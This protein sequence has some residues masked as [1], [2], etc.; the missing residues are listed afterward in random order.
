MASIPI[1]LATRRFAQLPQ[2]SA[3]TWQG[4]LVKLPAWVGDPGDANA[5]PHRVVGALWVSLRTGLVHV[6]LPREGEQPSAELALRALFEFGQKHAKELAGRPARLEVDDAAL[7]DELAVALAPT[8]T[9]VDVVEDLPHV[10]TVLRSFEEAATGGERQPG[11]L[12]AR[13]VT[14]AHVDGFAGAAAAFYRRA[15]WNDLDN[16]DLL[17][18]AAPAA[19]RGWGPYLSVMGAAGEE[20]GV[21]F[22]ETERAF[23]RLLEGRAP[24]RTRSVSFGPIHELPFAD[25]DAWDEQRLPVAGPDAYPIAAEMSRGESIRRPDAG[26]LVYVEAVLRALAATTAAELDA[27]VWQ[28]DVETATGSIAV[29]VS[30]PRIVEALAGHRS[31]A[32]PAFGGGLRASERVH[33]R[34]ARALEGRS[35]ESLDDA[36]ATIEQLRVDG[37]LDPDATDTEHPLA[38]AD[39]AQELAWD[40]AEASGRLRIALARRALALWPDCADAWVILGNAARTDEEALDC[41]GR[42]VDAGE[43]VL[44]ADRFAEYTGEF[45]VHLETRPYMRARLAL[46]QLLRERG[47][48]DEAMAHYHELLRLNPGDNQGIR[49]LLIVALLEHGRDEE[50]GELFARYGEDD[51][52]ALWLYARALWLLR[53]DGDQPPAR[54]ALATAIARNPHVVTCLLDEADPS[55]PGPYFTVGSDEEGSY[56]AVELMDVFDAIPGADAWMRANRPRSRGGRRQRPS[57]PARRAP[58]RR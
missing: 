10:K 1:S 6:A 7:R 29:A 18:V 9:A 38:P 51:V 53:T 21:I 33:A 4:G 25:A 2:R 36:N 42:A 11:Q 26:A 27:G 44:G 24:G 57:R 28:R 8:A 15:I 43:R 50:A 40:A 14:A 35:F 13:G 47:Q 58:G 37:A 56:A 55:P 31:N 45:W 39:A 54:E 17:H 19:P 30:L 52:Q 3:E 48:S 16:E 22:F 41:Y 20:F 23:E 32:T 49:Y 12:E 34:L 5:P 46:A